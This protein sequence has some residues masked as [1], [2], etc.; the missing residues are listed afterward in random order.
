MVISSSTEDHQQALHDLAHFYTNLALT[1]KPLK[2]VSFVYDGRQVDRKTTFYLGD[3]KTRNIATGPTRFLGQTLYHAPLSTAQEAGKRLPSEFSRQLNNLN[4]STIRGEV[5]LWIY[6][7]WFTVF[8][9]TLL[10]TPYS[11]P[12][13]RRCK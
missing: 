12:P 7:R 9:S 10:S 13:S 1:L 4:Q 8:T 5:K 6:R 11:H 3:G 2:C